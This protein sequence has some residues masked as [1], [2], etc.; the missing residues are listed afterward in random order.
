MARVGGIRRQLLGAYHGTAPGSSASKG[1]ER[2][3]FID[4]FLSQVLP[5]PFR[6]GTGD[7]TDAAGSRSGQLDVVVEYPLL[8]SLP[9]AG[10]SRYRLYLAEAIAACI[11]VK[12]NVAGQWD[13]VTRTAAKL[14]A[15]RRKLGGT[16]TELPGGGTMTRQQ[17]SNTF[18]NFSFGP[19]NP[20]KITQQAI[21]VGG[22]EHSPEVVPILAVGYQGWKSLDVLVGKLATREVDGILVLED[23]GLFAAGP[24]FGNH[25]AQ[26]DASLWEF[27]CC[28]HEATKMLAKH[29]TDPRDYLA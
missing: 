3:F 1:A 12:S 13:E 11:E 16:T 26:G 5:S 14:R 21:E 22:R 27:I 17:N 19:G 20:L 4:L 6:F 25:K 10:G 8:P 15:L 28:L 29:S 24:R 2:E 18:T 9:L 7:A 23:P